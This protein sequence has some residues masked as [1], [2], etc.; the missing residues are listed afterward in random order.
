MA[1]SQTIN[2]REKSAS[3]NTENIKIMLI[4]I[5][6]KTILCYYLHMNICGCIKQF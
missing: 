6:H 1:R 5:S 3:K 2:M 4:K